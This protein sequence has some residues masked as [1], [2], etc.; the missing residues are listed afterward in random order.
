MVFF[1]RRSNHSLFLHSLLQ[2]IYIFSFY[3]CCRCRFFPLLL[4]LLLSVNAT[5]RTDS[6]NYFKAICLKARKYFIKRTFITEKKFITKCRKTGTIS[7]IKYLKALF[8]SNKTEYVC[9]RASMCVPMHNNS[10]YIFGFGV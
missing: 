1:A 8:N 2:F 9:V 5:R 10:I 6:A 3:S 4:F 7:F